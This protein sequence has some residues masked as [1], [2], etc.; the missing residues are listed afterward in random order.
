ML[1]EPRGRVDVGVDLGVVLGEERLDLLD[2]LFLEALV[3]FEERGVL[4]LWS[5]LLMRIFLLL[6]KNERARE[7]KRVS[8]KEKERVRESEKE[9]ELLTLCFRKKES[10]IEKETDYS[11]HAPNFSAS[12]RFFLIFF[13]CNRET[14]HVWLLRQTERA[15]KDRK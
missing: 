3:L 13:A 14:N 6:R 8:E 4:V 11:K 7:R 12:L 5:L 2:A 15:K 10:K 9:R 1:G